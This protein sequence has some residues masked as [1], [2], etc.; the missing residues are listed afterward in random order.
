LE[1][2]RCSCSLWNSQGAA[3]RST[4]NAAEVKSEQ[5]RGRLTEAT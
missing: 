3:D 2:Q 5:E 4:A 1:K